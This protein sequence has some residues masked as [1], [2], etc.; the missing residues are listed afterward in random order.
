MQLTHNQLVTGRLA[1]NP[2]GDMANY[3]WKRT[4]RSAGSRLP[5]YRDSIRGNKMA[6]GKN[7]STVAELSLSASR[8]DRSISPDTEYPLITG[9]IVQLVRRISRFQHR[10]CT[11]TVSMVVFLT[12]DR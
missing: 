10:D 6:P 11:T 1:A 5:R 7:P 8:R 12:F 9:L 3:L 2:I 4:A